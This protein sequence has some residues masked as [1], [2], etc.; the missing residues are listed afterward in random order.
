MPVGTVVLLV[1]ITGTA[2][3]KRFE[4]NDKLLN[5]SVTRMETAITTNVTRMDTAITANNA[6]ANEK[7]INMVANVDRLEKSIEKLE[8]SIEKKKWW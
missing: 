4:D 7:I 2:T 6:L 5:A 8:A 3:E 1:S